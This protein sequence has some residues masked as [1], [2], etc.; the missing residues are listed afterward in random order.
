M[1]HTTKGYSIIGQRTINIAANKMISGEWAEK[2][3]ND[4]PQMRKVQQRSPNDTKGRD[5]IACRT[6]SKRVLKDKVIT[7]LSILKIET[8]RK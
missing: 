8:S 3:K 4:E 5:N 1:D 7:T 2:K 6:R